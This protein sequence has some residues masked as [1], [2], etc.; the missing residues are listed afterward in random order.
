MDIY[1]RYA[2]IDVLYSQTD[3]DIDTIEKYSDFELDAWCYELGYDWD[4]AER[5]YIYEGHDPDDY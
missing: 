2:A 1:Q 4:E 3:V 5:C